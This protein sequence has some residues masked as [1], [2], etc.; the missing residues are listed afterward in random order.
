MTREHLTPDQRRAVETLG[1][2]LVVTAGPGAGKTRVLVERVLR[3]L[4]GGLANMDEIVAIT[5]TN[6]AANEMKAKIRLALRERMRHTPSRR[7]HEAKRQLETAAIS[8]I[9]GFCARLLRAHPIAAQVDPEFVI[10]D[11]FQSRVLLIRAVEEV[12]EEGIEAQDAILG[13]LVIGYSRRG[14]IEAVADLYAMARALGMHVEQVLA[15]TENKRR[16]PAD[17][18]AMV[19]RLEEIVRRLEALPKPTERM[20]AQIAAFVRTYRLYGPLLRLEPRIEDITVLE[21]CMR[22][23]RDARIEKRGRLSELAAEVEACL[24]EIELTFYDACAGETIA[25]LGRLLQRVD[26]RYATLKREAIGLDYEDLQWKARELLR[27]QAAIADSVRREIKFLLVDEFQDTNALQKEVLDLLRG[28]GD[29]P[30]LFIVGDAKQSIYNFRGAAVEVFLKAQRELQEQGGAHI[31]LEHNFR[32]TAKLVHFFNAFFARLMHVEEGAWTAEML[33]AL[34]RTPFVESVARREG[35][36]AAPVELLLE[37]GPHVRTAEDARRWEAQRLAERIVRMVGEGELLVG[38]EQGDGRERVRAVRYGDIALLF[39]AM[40]DVKVYERALRERGIPYYVLAGRGFYER[41]EI[42][43]LLSLLQFLE[44]AT[45]EIA[46]AATLRSPLFGLSDEAL[47]WLRQAAEASG[48]GWLDPHPLLTSLQHHEHAWGI[49][50]QERPRVARA[51]EVLTRLLHLRDRL[52]LVELLQ[53]ILALTQFDAIQ[54]TAFD[55]H[56]RVANI[57]KLIELA[58][59]FEAS[60]PRTLDEF[61]A[62][63][64]QF[65]E[66]A[67]ESEA[68][69]TTETADAVRL[70]TVHKAKGLE[71]P[72]VILPDLGRPFRKDAPPLIFDRAA[73]I[74]MKIPDHRGRLHDTWSRRRV[75]E[76]LRLR[77]HFEHQRLLFVAMTRARDYL[78]LSGAAERLVVQEEEAEAAPILPG[79]SWLEWIARVLG[80]RSIEGLPEEYEWNGVKIRITL[81]TGEAL[82]REAGASKPLIARYPQLERGEPVASSLLPPLSDDQRAA[83]ERVLSRL[84][85]AL[86]DIGGSVSPIAVTRVLA[87]HRCPLQFYF[88]SVLNLPAWDEV[89]EAREPSREI[90]RVPSTLRGR[91]VHRFCE[92]YDGSEPWEATLDRLVEEMVISGASASSGGLADV[93]QL[94]NQEAEASWDE[95]LRVYRKRVKE[96]VRPLVETYVRSDLYRAIE[97]ILWGEKPGRVESEREILYRTAWGIVRGRLDKLIWTEDEVAWIVDFKTNRAGGDLGALVEEYALQMQIYALAAQRAW[98]PRAVRAELYFLDPNVRVPVPVEAFDETA[99][100]LERLTEEIARAR[101]LADFPARPEPDRC[102]RCPCAG[103][104]PE[105][106]V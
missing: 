65:A 4:E 83:M 42:R 28:G 80:L 85:P 106:A 50:A 16:T 64:Q 3:I 90:G 27:T 98:R 11:E 74:G 62:F 72:V 73:G 18:Q 15:L 56:Q 66:M 47:F 89:D 104:C 33:E 53:E 88:E 12:I 31:E 46:L 96:D 25:A 79:A 14:L 39:R 23:L 103:F 41:E 81:G 34:G 19:E 60:G 52:S 63:V 2:S 29:R 71:F 59:E 93:A 94:V 44:N 78:V 35:H 70:M 13:R 76:V 32:S 57:R 48:D 9:H 36:V 100:L 38:E 8:T 37:V 24:E 58:R 95:R 84:A 92:E 6:K 68:Q 75:L 20:A 67:E 5:F 55:G 54:A 30:Q 99:T 69:V 26:E 91:I 45:D 49:A 40:T 22:A 87:F 51:A 17:Y 43:D 10:L 7:W 82:K 61:T 102:R 86:R 21:E 101:T 97:A 1:R 105:R 77:E